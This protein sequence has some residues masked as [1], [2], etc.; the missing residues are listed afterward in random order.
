MN[1]LIVE[2]FASGHHGKYL[3]WIT[4]S[5]IAR[6]HHIQLGTFKESLDHSAMQ[7]VLSSCGQN[8]SVVSEPAQRYASIEGKVWSMAREMLKFRRI[9]ASLYAE[10]VQ[11]ERVD[12]VLLPYLDYC[13][14]ALALLGS[15]FGR[16]AW[17]GIVMRSAF[18]YSSMG[19]KAPQ[20]RSDPWKERLFHRLLSSRHL[21]ALFTID[22]TLQEY[23][24]GSGRP[25]ASRLHYI[26]DVT[27]PMPAM[28]RQQA[29]QLLGI[30][31]SGKVILV[32]GALSSRKGIDVLMQATENDAFPSDVHIVLSGEQPAE[33]EDILRS[34]TADRLRL[35][36]RLHEIKRYLTN[37]ES[38]AVFSAADFVWVGYRRHYLMSGILV[39]AASAGLPV[40]ACEE[41]LIGW[42]TRRYRAGI[43]VSTSSPPSIA[44]AVK[45][46]CDNPELAHEYGENGR[47]AYAS[48]TQEN[49]GRIMLDAI[50]V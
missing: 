6:G 5:I 44:R 24:H 26:P 11:R 7:E 45:E 8:L 19:V 43:V 50:E 20:T 37:A 39:Q 4:S 27:E 18:H 1:I 17:S 23:I 29:R 25:H 46:L 31:V 47:M 35:D 38:A 22:K 49:V 34:A 48:H 40:I 21:R 15:P 3:Q 32:Y 2:P 41:G 13:T 30:P 36:Y 9:M 14:Y 12:M 28:N 10:A 33:V 16:T 42:L